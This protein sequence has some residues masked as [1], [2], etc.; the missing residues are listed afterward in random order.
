MLGL[1]S[2][3]ADIFASYRV[4]GHFSFF[5]NVAARY[6]II[7]GTTEEINWTWKEE[8]YEKTTSG[9]KSGP[10]LEGKFRIQPTIGIAWKF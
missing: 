3:G 9:T 6:F 8:D 4:S 1:L 7:G 2:A 5:A 10:D